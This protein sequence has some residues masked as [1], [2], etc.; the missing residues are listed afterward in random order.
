M[1][2]AHDDQCRIEPSPGD[3]RDMAC[4]LRTVNGDRE[5]GADFSH[6]RFG[7]S[8]QPFNESCDRDA[9]DRVE[10][11][12][13]AKGHGVI[14]GL[15]ENFARE[16]S[17]GGRAGGDEG[18]TEAWDDGVTRQDNDRSTVDLRHLAPPDLPA[19]WELCHEAPT[20]RRN[21]ARSPHSSGSS[22]GCSSYAA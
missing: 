18:P 7:Q 19:R 2:R 12:C 6:S 3:D 4:S 10:I 20:A 5:G 13:R 15:E 9:F 1:S 11:D 22:S 16:V 8:S 14:S 21:E 17:D